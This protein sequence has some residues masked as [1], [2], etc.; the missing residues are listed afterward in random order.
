MPRL[1][2]NFRLTLIP[3]LIVCWS[4]NR[5]D[6]QSRQSGEIR[7]TVSDQSGAVIPGVTV[8]ITNVLSGVSQVVT[9]DS[10]GVY[11]AP[12]VPV[13]EYS[14]TFSRDTF[15]SYVRTGITLHVETITLNAVLQLG[16]VS[17]SVTVTGEV[18]QVQ[19]ETAEKSTTLTQQTVID[20]PN[21]GRQWYN[22]LGLLPGV[23][24]GGGEQ[25]SGEGIGVNG[26]N[27][28]NSNWQID[29]GIAMLGQSQNPDILYPPME[30]I[31][32]INL[33]TANFGAEHGNGLSVF[34]VI[35]KSGTNRFH[36][37]LYEYVENDKLNALNYFASGTTPLRWNE[38]GGTLGG[39]IK[40]DKA[41][42]FLSL[43]D[44]PTI[45]YSPQILTYPTAAMRT[46]DFSD[47]ALQT[48]YDPASLYQDASGNWIRTPFP[49]NKIPQSRFDPVASAI[50]QYFPA[51]NLGGIYN[52][53]YTAGPAPLYTNWI[54]GKIDY[55]FSPKNR[56]SGSFMIVRQNQTIY[57]PDCSID[58]S[59]FHATETLGQITD[60]YT[61]SP[62]LVSEFRF[63]YS[64]EHGIATVSSEGEGYPAK[65]GLKN[66]AADLF[67]NISIE[68]T[69]STAIGNSG[70]P[71]AVDAETTF[72]PS[73]VISWVKGKHIVKFG[74]E[75]DRWWVNVGWPNQNEGNFDFNGLFTRNP[76]DPNSAGEGYADF[77]FG[78][79]DTWSV[80]I[81]PT[82][83][84]RMWSTQ[85]FVQDEYKIKP[86]LTLTLGL[87]YVIQSGWS[88]V[89]NRLSS[90][91]P[92]VIN[93]A[94]NTP[95]GLWFAGQMG[96]R[97]LTD[98]IYD[99][100]APRVGFAWSPKN[101]WSV[102]GGFGI[103][104]V[105]A[106]QN[107]YGNLGWGQGWVVQGFEQ[108]TDNIHP[109]FQLVQ[110]PPEPLYPAARD[111]TP[112]L[113][114]GQAVNYSLWHSPLGY[115]EEYQFDIQHQLAS[116]VT[117]DVGYVGNRGI[118]MPFTRDI[119]QVPAYLLGPGDAQLKRPYPNFAG[120]SAAFFDGISLYNALQ[121]VAKK[122]FA[123]GL[124]FQAS[125]SWSK[126]MDTLTGSGWG[127]SGASERVGQGWQDA[128]NWKL[129]YGPSASDVRQMLNGNFVYYFPVGQ[130]K[131]FLNQGGVL[132]GILGGWELSSLFQVRSGLPF[133]PVMATANLSG[134]LA[135][136]WRP[137][138]LA[139]G[140]L[141]NP[142]INLWYDPSAFAM[143]AEYTFGD[144]GR[145]ILYGPSWKDI[146]LALMKNF[147]IRKLGE[148][149]KIQIK[150]EAFDAFNLPNFGLPNAHLGSAA[151]GTITYA[152]TNRLL[153]L[154]AK[155]SF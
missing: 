152:N 7:G 77:L 143:P 26:Q 118:H 35:T 107:S 46:G 119:N 12:Y 112:D 16:S 6:A 53:F 65:L 59:A 33:N 83:G 70:F 134:S 37:D 151:A 115:S 29:G 69:V 20:T 71:P 60:V 99:F 155:L 78:L 146:D 125:Y 133:T 96:H 144:S 84:G 28:Y 25:A 148:Q 90:F 105:L 40:R 106:G 93:P 154:G 19:T 75:F 4:F 102:R 126:S 1:A 121:V 43:Q 67:P 101:N 3:V 61:L 38:F 97:A 113:L 86:N 103:Y 76:N 52:N 138:R 82:D 18:S 66:P 23:N 48:I 108:T 47:P 42:F 49:G 128:Y 10:T 8:T 36:G 30:A 79:P 14:V 110:G 141:T 147:A 11:D 135:G 114:N 56:L 31:E 98:T 72:V 81:I 44:N 130:G 91:E 17:D 39:P 100:F 104:N 22:L 45:T 32:E 85:A 15:K 122:Q 124:V 87:R 50:Q 54:S 109:T 129:N 117:L 21:V 63:S 57:A 132:N 13:G 24:P 62:N 123:N 2:V 153:Q 140:T 64:R 9:T 149:G 92:N 73:E 131:R 74:G 94:T 80:S 145:D 136:D 88:E 137:N 120:I 27:S 150:A 139:S 5:A 34:N 127:G 142:S 95:G 58:C 55:N 68:G 111:R 41:F 51:P 116:G 89:A